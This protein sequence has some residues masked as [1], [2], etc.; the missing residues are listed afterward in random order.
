MTLARSSY[1]APTWLPGGHAQ[2]IVAAKLVPRPEVLY[3]RERLEAPDGDFVDLDFALPEPAQANAPLLVLFHGLEGSS[4]SHYALALMR[5]AADRGWRGVV[6]HFRGCSGEPNRLPRAYH[7]GDSDEADW[8]LRRVHASYPGAALHAV[9]V[10]LGGNVLAKW[11]GERAEDAAFVTAAAS[12]GSPLDLVAGG[13]AISRG[14][15]RL[16]TRMFL[17]TLK[18]KVTEKLRRFP[19]L[20]DAQRLR[21]VRTM[22]DFDDFY[23]APV[24]GYA[25]ALDYWTRAS[26]KPWLPGVRVPHLVLNA[27]ND[28]F[29]PATS[30]PQPGQ[31]SRFVTLEQ[32]AQGGHIGFPRGAPPG[33]LGFLPERVLDFF[34]RG[35]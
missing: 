31:V 25:G 21:A 1:L 30:L 26:G 4:G 11:L 29:V 3:R 7:S 2:T 23:T 16:Y 22:F 34:E 32:P 24:H 9:G 13:E 18:P 6:V 14:F 19:G 17:A 33:D 12:I 27:L 35:Q 20:L 15:N 5:A 28:P 10:S 8:V